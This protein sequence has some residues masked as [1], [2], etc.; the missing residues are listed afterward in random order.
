MDLL[1]RL[2]DDFLKQIKEVIRK[3]S[4]NLQ[5]GENTTMLPIVPNKRGR[6]TSTKLVFEVGFSFEPPKFCKDENID[7][8]KELLNL[9]EEGASRGNHVPRFS[10]KG[11]LENWLLEKR[12][13][14]TSTTTSTKEERKTQYTVFLTNNI[15]SK[16][17]METKNETVVARKE[18]WLSKTIENEDMIEDHLNKLL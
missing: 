2:S 3:A 12:E 16:Q 14:C 15:E 9:Y 4:E 5:H 6:K 8:D 13:R 1:S 18:S 11:R 7:L 17:N 10:M